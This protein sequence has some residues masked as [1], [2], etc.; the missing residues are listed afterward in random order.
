MALNEIKILIYAISE[1]TV[2]ISTVSRHPDGRLITS[3]SARP[4]PVG[5]DIKKV[6]E[7]VSV[8]VAVF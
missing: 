1:K 8:N 7:I 5:T 2:S 4:I 6:D 3:K